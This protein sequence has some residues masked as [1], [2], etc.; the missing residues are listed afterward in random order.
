MRFVLCI[1]AFWNVSLFSLVEIN[2]PFGEA[3]SLS[4]SRTGKVGCSKTC[5][6]KLQGVTSH[7][8]ACSCSPLWEPTVYVKFLSIVTWAVADRAAGFGVGSNRMNVQCVMA[9]QDKC[10][11]KWIKFICAAVNISSCCR[12]FTG[13]K[14]AASD[15]IRLLTERNVSLQ[16]NGC[17]RSSRQ[18]VRHQKIA[19]TG[20]VS[21]CE[22]MAGHISLLS[23][24]CI[25]RG[26]T[27]TYVVRWALKKFAQP[28]Y[29]GML[30]IYLLSELV[31]IMAPPVYPVCDWVTTGNNRR[32]SWLRWRVG[33]HCHRVTTQF[34]LINIIIII[35]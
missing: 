34:Q 14:L 25:A 16:G 2:I 29:V 19:L 17:G 8:M 21:V 6:L 27:S 11:R 10:R 24:R 5:L 9:A 32:L 35:I 12:P 23:G 28:R 20:N 31:I 7:N 13:C 3:H 33:H 4:L 18:L 15:M 1:T 26:M 22:W 30:G